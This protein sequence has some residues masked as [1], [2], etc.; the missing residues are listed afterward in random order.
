MLAS[1]WSLVARSR[2]LVAVVAGCCHSHWLAR[3]WVIGHTT[4]R[5]WH[6][7]VIG[8]VN[9]SLPL[10][11][12]H[13]SIITRS[14]GCRP[15]GYVIN[16]IVNTVINTGHRLVIVNGLVIN[17]SHHGHHQ[18][19]YRWHW[20]PGHHYHTKAVVIRLPGQVRLVTGSLAGQAGAV[21][22]WLLVAGWAGYWV[23]GHCHRL[24]GLVGS[25]GWRSWRLTIMAGRAVIGW[26][27]QGRLPAGIA[28]RLPRQLPPIRSLSSLVNG[29]ASRVVIG[30]GLA[31]GLAGP[32]VGWLALVIGHWLLQ[33]H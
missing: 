5:H 7:R 26:S 4:G 9:G 15:F 33:G 24:A 11:I 16:V 29:L 30:H 1:H 20:S 6:C 3:H 25:L 13:G 17:G 14:Q 23:G 28:T 31:A 21:S 19:Y 2:L 27:S 18:Q 22:H 8:H 32:L 12:G 10:A